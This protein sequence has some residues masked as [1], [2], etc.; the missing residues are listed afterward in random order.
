MEK[1]LF[2]SSADPTVG[3]GTIAMDYFN[4]FRKHG[5]EVDFLTKYKVEHHPE[6]KYV[7]SKEHISYNNRLF[8]FWRKLNK[9]DNKGLHHIFY[10][11]ENRPPVNI[12]KILNQIRDDYDYIVIFFWQGLLSYKSVEAIFNKMKSFVRVIFRCADYSPMTGG[13]HFMVD[14]QRYKYGCGCCEMVRSNNPND[15]T[16]QN[17]KERTRINSIIKPI[18]QVNSYMKIFFEDSPAMNSGAVISP[19][20]MMLNLDM[21]KPLDRKI[22]LTKYEV[23]LD[24]FVIFFGCQ[25]FAEKRKGMD[26][27]MDSLHI[28]FEQLD[29]ANREKIF[30]ITAGEINSDIISKVPFKSKHFGFVSPTMLPEL[31]SMSSVYLS[32]SVNDAGPSMVNQ[33][34]ACGTPVIAFEIGTALEVIKDTGAGECVPL[35]N[36][37]AFALAIKKI[38]KLNK[39]DYLRMREISRETAIKFH[40][41]KAFIDSFKSALILWD[42]T[43]NT[44]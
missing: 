44:K 23:P 8:T 32:P 26:Y 12:D 16:A 41:D 24:N 15:F 21:F 35:K 20:T 31:Y 36:T 2:I 37:E 18:V 27:L 38:M 40:S 25:T 29:E 10:R 28:L 17:M 13:C 1:I 22:L 42:K 33:S 3:P 39:V 6:I 7:F 5:Y 19:S 30:V 14:C 9:V 43:Y 34:I 4:A 11:K